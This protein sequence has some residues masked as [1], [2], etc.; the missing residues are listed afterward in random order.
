MKTKTCMVLTFKTTASER[1]SNV[2]RNTSTDRV[3]VDNPTLSIEAT[4]SRTR[5]DTVLVDA[6][7]GG[8]TVR[9]DHTLGSTAAVG[10]AK[11]FWSTAAD[12][13][14]A[15]DSGISIGPAWIGVAGV[16]GRRRCCK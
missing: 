14:T 15:T 3:V 10:I 13:G 2:S 4:D 12:T 11:V 9:V 6:G 5:I 7:L 1:I 8:D 16:S